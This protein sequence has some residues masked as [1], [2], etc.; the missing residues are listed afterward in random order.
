MKIFKQC[1]N[2]AITLIVLGCII[3]IFG[4]FGTE[5]IEYGGDAYTGIQNAAADTANNVSKACGILVASLGVVLI[6]YSNIKAF[7]Y[8]EN[9]KKHK[10][11]LKALGVETPE[12]ETR[13][14][15][16]NLGKCMLCH[17]RD[18]VKKCRVMTSDGVK[19]MSI[20]QTCFLNGYQE[21]DEE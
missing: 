4:S 5:Y 10:E 20:C 19:T 13:D 18:A 2:A 17:E 6:N 12:T 15:P 3:F 9:Q 7:E 1:K 21:K 16:T 14:E 8:E 11:L